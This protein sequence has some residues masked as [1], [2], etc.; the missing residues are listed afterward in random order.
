MFIKQNKGVVVK[1]TVPNGAGKAHMS[2]YL[3]L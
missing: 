2:L 3:P 1:Q